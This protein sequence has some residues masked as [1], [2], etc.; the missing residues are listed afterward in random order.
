LLVKS[1]YYPTALA[2]AGAILGHIFNPF[3]R[4]RGGKGVS[5]TIGVAIGLMPKSFVISLAAWIIVYL[6]TYIIALASISFAITLPIITTILQ[7]AELIDRIFMLIMALL[8]IYAHRSN[9]KRIIKK[10][11]PR[12]VLWRKK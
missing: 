8:I 3:F 11:E 12:T 6:A 2:G 5:T 7:E 1:F 9:I 4:F 10:E